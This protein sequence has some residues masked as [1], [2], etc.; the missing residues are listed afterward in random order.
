[1]KKQLKKYTKRS[2]RKPS[3][4]EAEFTEESATGANRHTLLPPEIARVLRILLL[5]AWSC[6]TIGFLTFSFELGLRSP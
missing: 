3:P 1:V 2:V 6:E 5:T 4:P